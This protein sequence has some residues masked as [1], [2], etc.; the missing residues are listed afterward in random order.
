M[1]TALNNIKKSFVKHKKIEPLI[2]E[3]KLKR[4][5][6]EELKKE[7]QAE[8]EEEK[9]YNKSEESESEED[10]DIIRLM[11]LDENKTPAERRLKW[12][13]KEKKVIEKKDKEEKDEKKRKVIPT[14][15]K[16]YDE[17]EKSFLYRAGIGA[18]LC[19]CVRFSN[20]DSNGRLCRQR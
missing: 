14:K 9:E 4:P 18:C 3:Y 7:E 10:V 8:E 16:F 20:R 15:S 6:E 12:V 11:K 1:N 19:A 17:N 2:K 13:K 5:S